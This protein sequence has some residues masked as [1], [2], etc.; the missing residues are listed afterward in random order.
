MIQKREQALRISFAAGATSLI[1]F[2]LLHLLEPEF[3]PIW[4]FIS[5]Y[6]LGKFGWMMHLVFFSIVVSVIS[7]F[8]AV[9]SYIRGVLAYIGTFFLII[10]TIGFILATIFTSDPITATKASFNGML[11]STG[12]A[13]GGHIGT[14]ALFLGLSFIRNKSLRPFRKYFIWITVVNSVVGTIA[15]VTMSTMIAQSHNTFGP[16]LLV[17][18]PNRVL[19]ITYPLWLMAISWCF[20][21]VSKQEKKKMGGSR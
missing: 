17:G 4:R 14:A 6:Q 13:L 10:G 21:Q 12:A 3:D 2:A 11:H 5:E 15:G 1:I 8:M 9:R 20:I 16:Q 18:I 7:F 19:F